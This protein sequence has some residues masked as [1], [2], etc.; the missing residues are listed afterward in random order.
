MAADEGSDGEVWATPTFGRGRQV[1]GD[2]G[3]PPAPPTSILTTSQRLSRLGIWSGL[4]FVLAAAVLLFPIGLLALPLVI[5]AMAY[6]TTRTRPWPELLALGPGIAAFTGLVAWGN[7]DSRPCSSQGLFVIGPGETGEFSCG[8]TAPG[9]WLVVS[10]ALVAVAATGY[11][12]A[13][14]AQRRRPRPLP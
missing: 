6:L 8:G 7:R 10:I 5:V 4:G 11:V 13:L 1:G 12:A 3:V 2:F 9:P 14:V